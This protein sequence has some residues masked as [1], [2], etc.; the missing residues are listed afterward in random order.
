MGIAAPVGLGARCRRCKNIRDDVKTVQRLLNRFPPL[1]GG[2]LP[3]LVPDGYVG[4]LTDKAIGH[5]QAKWDIIPKYSKKTGSHR[6]SGRQDDRAP[7]RGTD[8]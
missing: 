7:E 8:G 2:P 6:R 4:P 3:K 5:F 1:E